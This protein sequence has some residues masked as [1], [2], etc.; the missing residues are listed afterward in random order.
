MLKLP[1]GLYGRHHHGYPFAPVLEGG[2]TSLARQA[3]RAFQVV[4]MACGIVALEAS[5]PAIDAADAGFGPPSISMDIEH[6]FMAAF[7]IDVP[8]ASGAPGVVEPDRRPPGQH[9]PDL[10]VVVFQEYAARYF[11]VM[12]TISA[13]MPFPVSSRVRFT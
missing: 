11:R 3:L 1:G 6:P 10:H 5:S 13:M 7:I 8:D 4:P 2:I 12:A 9:A